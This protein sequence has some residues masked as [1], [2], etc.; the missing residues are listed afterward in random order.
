MIIECNEN[1]IILDNTTSLDEFLSG[2]N[3]VIYVTN[4]VMLPDKGN[5]YVIVFQRAGELM[6]K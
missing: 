5:Y 2:E 1:G 6:M 4:R 3:G